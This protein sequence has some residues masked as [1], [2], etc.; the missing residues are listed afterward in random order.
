MKLLLDTCVLAEFAKPKTDQNVQRFI[1]DIA[2]EALF[3][4][5]ISLG[6]I[7]KGIHLLTTSKRKTHLQKW[8][9]TLEMTYQH[10]VLPINAEIADLWGE[11]AA[12]AQKKGKT[13]HSADGL[14]TATA[15]IHGL[16]LVTRNTKDFQHTPVLLINPW[17]YPQE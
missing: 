10:R 1:Q 11:I 5:V 15:I 4:S 12:L 7:N 3:I 8:M 2:S 16:H 14:L 6:E 13:L 17:E 9:K